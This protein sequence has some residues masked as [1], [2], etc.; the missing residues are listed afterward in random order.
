MELTDL[1]PLESEVVNG[2]QTQTGNKPPQLFQMTN[3]FLRNQQSDAMLSSDQPT[4][5]VYADASEDEKIINGTFAA[6]GWQHVAGDSNGMVL[7]DDNEPATDFIGLETGVYN[8]KTDV[9]R[10]GCFEV[11]RTGELGQHVETTDELLSSEDRQEVIIDAQGEICDVVPDS[12]E[13]NQVLLHH[14]RDFE[15]RSFCVDKANSHDFKIPNSRSY[16]E[17]ETSCVLPTVDVV[18][19]RASHETT[20]SDVFEND[21]VLKDVPEADTA[22]SRD[23]EDGVRN[24]AINAS[25]LLPTADNGEEKPVVAISPTH[26]LDYEDVAQET[27]SHIDSESVHEETTSVGLTETVREGME[28]HR[29]DLDPGCEESRDRNPYN[30]EE[31]QTFDKQIRDKDGGASNDDNDDERHEDEVEHA[32]D[33]K[34]NVAEDNAKDEKAKSVCGSE[35]ELEKSRCDL[36]NQEESLGW[37]LTLNESQTGGR[38]Q[39]ESNEASE[40]DNKADR[41]NGIEL[42][43][44]SSKL[45]EQSETTQNEFS[46][47]PRKLKLNEL[48][49]PTIISKESN[50]KRKLGGKKNFI[51][52]NKALLKA[53]NAKR[54]SMASNKIGGPQSLNP[55]QRRPLQ[56]DARFIFNR[57]KRFKTGALFMISP[58]YRHPLGLGPGEPCRCSSV[59][60]PQC[61]SLIHVLPSKSGFHL[62]LLPLISQFQIVLNKKKPIH[63]LIC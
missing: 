7:K 30:L 60:S 2:S 15:I 11:P 39:E 21:L 18:L 58:F 12:Y 55:I 57:E 13:K 28:G 63:V 49:D 42:L 1:H 53:R 44:Q 22:Q 17:D 40:Q 43:E 29:D 8:A 45:I 34:D 25:Y 32:Q 62:V 3:N 26:L 33:G 36:A 23:F 4:G 9:N 41:T 54:A 10:Y 52:M 48:S 56:N 27:T 51:A 6:T 35:A 61:F 19:E 16:Q 59:G 24:F 5:F 37:P 46:I 38:G 14:K 47:I 50:K 20:S 31:T